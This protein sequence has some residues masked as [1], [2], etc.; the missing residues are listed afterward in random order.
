MVKFCR[1]LVYYFFVFLIDFD[2]K[3]NTLP[4]LRHLRDGDIR[5]KKC[6]RGHKKT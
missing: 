1:H 4:T 6:E 3:Y 2:L 5:Y